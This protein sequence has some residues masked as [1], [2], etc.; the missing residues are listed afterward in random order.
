MSDIDT[1]LD[2]IATLNKLAHPELDGACYI[3]GINPTLIKQ[4]MA[5]EFEK[6]I[7]EDKQFAITEKDVRELCGY[8]YFF[9]NNLDPNYS[10]FLDYK[11]KDFSAGYDNDIPLFS[12]HNA[13]RL[14]KN[15]LRKRLEEW[16]K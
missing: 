13:D 11:T 3:C 16:K 15:K 1:R 7:G 6:L 10:A 12:Y 8:N 9:E 2:E 4:L 5:D 14:I